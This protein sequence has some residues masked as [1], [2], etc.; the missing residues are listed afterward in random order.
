MESNQSRDIFENRPAEQSGTLKVLTTLTFIGCGL[1]YIFT[2]FGFF[3]ATRY[4]QNKAKLEELMDKAGDNPMTA[5]MV[6]GQLDLL[7]KTYE[8]RYLLVITGLVFTTLCL[9]GAIQMRKR[10][11]SGFPIYTIGELAPVII[12]MAIL[13]FTGMFTL[14]TQIFGLVIA[15][16]FVIL[17][18]NQRKNLI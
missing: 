13:G 18:A 14:I 10:K 3:N 8:N 5:K 1:A 4:E 2:L 12:N 17:Y 11:K 15:L 7:Q 9:V 16:L 6:N